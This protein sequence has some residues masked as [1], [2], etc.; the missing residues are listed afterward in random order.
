MNLFKEFFCQ[1]PA[2]D[3]FVVVTVIEI[4]GSAPREVGARMAVTTSSSSHSIGGGNLEF[5]AIKRAREM[6]KHRDR[7]DRKVEFFGLGV[8]MSQCCGGAVRLM[9]ERYSEQTTTALRDFLKISSGCQKLFLASPVSDNETEQP[10]VFGNKDD[11]EALPSAVSNAARLLLEISEPS[12]RLVPDGDGEWFVTRVDE[13]PTKIVLF[14]AGHVG[15]AL[16][17]LLRDLPFQVDWVDQRSEMFPSDIPENTVAMLLEDPLQVLENQQPGTF[18]VVMTHDHGLD[19]EL[20]LR[21]L[22]NRDFG[23]LGLI[24]SEIKRRRFEQRFMAD[25]INAFTMKRLQCPIG[26]HDIRGK[27]PAVIAMSA[28]AQLLEAR[29]KHLVPQLRKTKD[30]TGKFGSSATS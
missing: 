5:Q 4:A 14:G 29:Q 26:I 7:P 27:F 15:K 6:L 18:Y 10:L 12:S 19:Y 22:R 28:A 24:G 11:W 16:V 17:K 23:W 25:G 20:C 2:P 21:I 3:T 9:F 30:E 8:T 13:Q 1:S